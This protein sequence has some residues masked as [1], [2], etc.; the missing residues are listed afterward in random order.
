M[1]DYNSFIS[2]RKSLL[3]APAGYG[4]TYTLAEC[5]KYTPDEDVQ[6]ILTHTHAGIASLKEK[7]KQQKIPSSKYHLETITG[8]AQKYV[9]AFYCGADSPAQENSKV[10]YPFIVTQA[11]E[12]FKRNSVLRVISNTYGGLFVDEYQDCTKNQHLMVKEL[13]KIL[14]THILGDSLQGIMDF[15]K[16]QLVDLNEDLKNFV[17]FP[18]LE[19]PHRWFQEGNNNELGNALKEIR[20][21]LLKDGQKKIDL[22]KYG[23]DII[24]V[25]KV[26]TSDIYDFQSRY[27]RGLSKLINNP[28]KETAFESLLII[29]PEYQENKVPKGDVRHRAEFKTRIDYSNRLVLLE[30]FDDKSFYSISINI[31]NII[32][33]HQRLRYVNKHI[34]E[35]IIEKLFNSGC[36]T[37]WFNHIFETKKKVNENKQKSVQLKHLF[38]KC[39]TKPTNQNILDLL[40]YLKDDL[41]FKYKKAR[42]S[43]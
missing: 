1:F 10:Y 23:N 13:S 42:I 34:I 40:V 31:D 5:V 43:I 24:S 27:F 26:K 41:K 36:V 20:E 22:K 38:D 28:N 19:T 29:M 30:A 14:P 11:I 2:E 6:L 12:L 9:N 21:E 39:V 15:G 18:D 7:I 25:L 32:K 8:F 3:V 33:S 16:E 37:D 35:D 17:R 4:K